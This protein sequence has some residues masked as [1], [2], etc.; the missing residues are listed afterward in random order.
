MEKLDGPICAQDEEDEDE[1]TVTTHPAVG[2]SPNHPDVWS[3]NTYPE[4]PSSARS[5]EVFGDT[6]A[7]RP[8]KK[9]PKEYQKKI[10]KT[11]GG[12]KTG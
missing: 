2:R 10:Q 6:G 11:N 12:K 8:P 7:P 5:K 1:T 4:P 3:E 9:I